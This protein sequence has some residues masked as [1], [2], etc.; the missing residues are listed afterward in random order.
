MDNTAQAGLDQLQR[1]SPL[2]YDLQNHFLQV[3]TLAE[4][5][6]IDGA[7]LSEIELISKHA[8]IAL[9]YALF[10]VEAMQTQLPFT[11]VS[12]AAAARDVTENLR[13]LAKAYDVELSLDITKTLEP[14][15]AN[16][17]ALRGALYSLASSLI[18]N[19]QTGKKRPK[20][21]VVA[22]ETTPQT[23]RLGVYSPD[24]MMPSS[25]LKLARSLAYRARFVAPQDLH[26]S[27]LGLI[28]SDQL[29]QALGSRLKWFTHR[30]QRG[31]GFYV[32]MSG[33]LG[34]L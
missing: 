11:S 23:Q 30:G 12:A 19:R 10:A 28:V 14:V 27:G 18:I 32:P 34:F 24:I 7:A 17:A 2:L 16:E 8:L 6:T 33:Q 13:L 4:M 31:I 20:V 5:A 22:Q 26:H 21:V 3:R 1:F 25:A 29:T 15:Y 9:D